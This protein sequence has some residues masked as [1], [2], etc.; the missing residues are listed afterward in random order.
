MLRLSDAGRTIPD[1]ESAVEFVQVRFYRMLGD[2]EFI[3]NI[4][5]AVPVEEHLQNIMLTR[6]NGGCRG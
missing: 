5:V 1:I 2:A 6:C 4:L 3:G